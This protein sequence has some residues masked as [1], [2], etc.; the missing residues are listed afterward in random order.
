MKITW[1]AQL[2][3]WISVRS[4]S[5]VLRIFLTLIYCKS[6]ASFSVVRV[7]A[8][9]CLNKL[10]KFAEISRPL[11]I[12]IASAIAMWMKYFFFF[13]CFTADL[14]LYFRHDISEAPSA[15]QQVAAW[16]RFDV[17]NKLC[18]WISETKKNQIMNKW[19][20]NKT[21]IPNSAEDNF[22][23]LLQLRSSKSDLKV[24]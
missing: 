9:S 20:V 17:R 13:F 16:S 12:A 7:L 4:F 18:N 2:W 8:H 1:K 11:D 15:S 22:I 5:Y 10:K 19:R 3:R 24:L 21:F 6:F 23:S 14:I